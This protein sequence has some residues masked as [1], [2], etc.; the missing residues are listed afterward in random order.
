M[1]SDARATSDAAG[2]T[3]RA[4]TPASAPADR[5]SPVTSA[6]ASPPGP[7]PNQLALVV[8]SRLDVLTELRATVLAWLEPLHLDENE[9]GAIPVVLS[10]LVAN[11][12]EAS[13][14][15]EPVHVEVEVGDDAVVVEVRNRSRRHEPVPLPAMADPLAPRGRGLAIVASLA[16]ELWLGE[17]DGCTVARATLPRS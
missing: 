11:A 14:A 1:V 13:R 16:D 3:R 9:M 12:V 5:L 10:E 15:G 4:S 8:D 17:V 7:A 6:S 2:S